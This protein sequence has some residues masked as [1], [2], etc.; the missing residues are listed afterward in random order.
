MHDI[1]PWW[2]WR[3]EYAAENDHKSPFYGREYNEFLFT[4]KIYNYYIHPQWDFF[5]SETLYGKLLFVDYG[6]GKNFALIELIGEWNDC[7]GNDIM[8]LKRDIADH[9]IDKGI[10]KFVL[11]CD[12]VLNYHGDDDCY[13]EEWYDDVKDDNGWICIINGYDHVLKEMEKFRL[14]YYM[15]MGEQYNEINWRAQKPAF[16]V[17]SIEEKMQNQQKLMF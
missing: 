1:E 3:D 6:R 4:N 12:N 14:Y 16:I 10:N 11:L 5:G 17:Q 13:Y 2:G 8:F 15:N 7:I 9:L